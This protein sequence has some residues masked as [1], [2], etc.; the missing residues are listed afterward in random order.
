MR[1]KKKVG[2]KDI[3]K[4]A[5]VS[6]VTV[7]NALAGRE[8]VSQDKRK[9]IFHIAEELGYP[10]SERRE[11]RHSGGFRFGVCT[12]DES[13]REILKRVAKRRGILLDNPGTEKE[14][15]GYIFAGEGSREDFRTFLAGHHEPVVGLG[16]FDREIPADYIVDDVFHG[17]GMAVRVLLGQ[18][19]QDIAAAASIDGQETVSCRTL[20]GV[21][22]TYHELFRD[23]W[24]S[25]A[26]D[27][28]RMV[29]ESDYRRFLGKSVLPDGIVCLDKDSERALHQDFHRRGIRIPDEV[30]LIA[31]GGRTELPEFPAVVYEEEEMADLCFQTLIRR[32]EQGSGPEGLQFVQGRYLEL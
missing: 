21:F 27:F 19:Q 9:E 29:Q 7:S 13:W 2:L 32:L 3:A 10:V 23:K 11:K 24:G 6:V 8:G 1:P 31:Y 26:P 4:R 12:Y 20:D 18:G 22:G 5:G 25:F 17:A 15:R 30:K 28:G 14:C 16:F